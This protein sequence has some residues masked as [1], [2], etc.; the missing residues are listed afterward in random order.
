MLLLEVEAL[1]LKAVELTKQSVEI[2]SVKASLAV[3]LS[4]KQKESSSSC[5]SV[6]VAGYNS[7]WSHSYISFNSRRW[8]VHVRLLLI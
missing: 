6:S 2:K 8:S 4:L 1:A 3:V 7:F 5:E